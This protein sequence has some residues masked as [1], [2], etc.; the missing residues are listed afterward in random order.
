MAYADIHRADDVQRQRQLGGLALN[1]AT[2]SGAATMAAGAGRVAGMGAGLPMCSAHAGANTSHAS[3]ASASTSM[4]SVRWRS[5][6]TGLPAR[7]HHRPPVWRWANGRPAISMAPAQHM[8][9]R[10]PTDS[11]LGDDVARLGSR[12]DRCAASAASRCS[13]QAKRSRGPTA[14]R[15]RQGW[16]REWGHRPLE[17]LHEL[18][19]LW[20]PNCDDRRAS[21]APTLAC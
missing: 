12:F 21:P 20:P 8:G 18:E 7:H 14:G 1:S 11:R 6:S 2:V 13:S 15:W 10:I 16:C 4:A 5:I 9:R 19:R 17:R 3:E